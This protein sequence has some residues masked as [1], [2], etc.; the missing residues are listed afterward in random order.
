MEKENIKKELQEIAPELA[1]IKN[2]NVF[3]VPEDY[4]AF[5]PEQIAEKISDAQKVNRRFSFNAAF[6]K[7]AVPGLAAVLLLI[8]TFLLLR[9]DKIN[10]MLPEMID[11]AQLAWYSEYHLEAFY[12][13]LSDDEEWQ[14]DFNPDAEHTEEYLLDYDYY[15][16]HPVINEESLETE[17]IN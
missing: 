5:L 17:T 3:S 6:H 10:G 9:N 7:F 1:D 16:M 8:S 4:F 12:Q 15:F 14:N 2:E 13:I 11:D